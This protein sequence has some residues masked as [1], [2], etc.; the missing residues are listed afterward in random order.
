[1]TAEQSSRRPNPATG[2]SAVDFLAEYIRRTNTHRFDEVAPLIA[3]DAVFWFSS[4][5]FHGVAAIRAA[6]ER[7]LAAIQDEDYAI[8]DVEWIA[9]DEPTAACLYTFRWR[10]LIDGAAREGSG[11]GTTVMRHDGRRWLIVH[12]HLSA[13]P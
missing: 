10:G 7:T 4:G 3:E 11:R 9:A 13:H 2:E 12:E 8:E 5:T 1:M 6:F